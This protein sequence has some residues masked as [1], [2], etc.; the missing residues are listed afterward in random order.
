[1]GEKKEGTE[2]DREHLIQL[3]HFTT[4]NI[5]FHYTT[6]WYG[7]SS[8]VESTTQNFLHFVFEYAQGLGGMEIQY[9]YT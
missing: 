5:T 6:V 1:M 4:H 7:T 3:L 9:K 8:Q 2:G